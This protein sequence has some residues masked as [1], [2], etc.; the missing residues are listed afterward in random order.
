LGIQFGYGSTTSIRYS[1]SA[2][3]PAQAS[4]KLR[5]W[6][7]LLSSNFNLGAGFVATFRGGFAN[8]RATSSG[9]IAHFSGSATESFVGGSGIKYELDR[10]LSVRIDWDQFKGPRGSQVRDVNVVSAG[11]GYNF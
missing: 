9:T 6:D 10:H 11:I 5:I 3:V 7:I 4:E 1:T 8:V 2:P